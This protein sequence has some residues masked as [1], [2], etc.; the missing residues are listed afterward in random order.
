MFL[1]NLALA[2]LRKCESE[3]L[4]Y[5]RAS[6][7]CGCSAKHFANIVNKRTS[8]TLKVFEHICNGFETTPNELLGVSPWWPNRERRPLK[9]EVRVVRRAGGVFLIPVCPQQNLLGGKEYRLCCPSELC[10][11]GQ[12][13][14]KAMLIFYP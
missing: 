9:V 1:E 3:R 13:F 8:P 14:E 4:S 10:V 5:E 6:E 12:E 11:F 2:L 7:R